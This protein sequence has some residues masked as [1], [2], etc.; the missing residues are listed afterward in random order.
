MKHRKASWSI[1]GAENLAKILTTKVNQNLYEKV[2]NISKIQLPEKYTKII[3]E[4]LSAAKSPKKEGNGYQYP[5]AG[6]IPFINTFV[7]NGRAAIKNMLG[8]RDF[9]DISY[10]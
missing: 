3:K 9:A 5:K 6:G 1:K 10:I 8:E 4:T 7:T 2:S